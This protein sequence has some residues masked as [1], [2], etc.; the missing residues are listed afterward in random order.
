MTVYPF[1]WIGCHKR[2]RAGQHFIK[3]DS[4]RVEVA[5][6]VNR[7]VDSS[8]LFGGHIRERS[9]DKLGGFRR[10]VFTGEMRCNTEAREP[11]LPSRGMYQHIRW[12]DILVD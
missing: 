8:R 3:G 10:L 12:L 7:P 9:C 4:E 6:G 2:E 11:H 1:H 5:P